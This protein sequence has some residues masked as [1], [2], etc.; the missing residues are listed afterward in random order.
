MTRPILLPSF[1]AGELSPA[2][3]GRVDLAKYQVGLATC[4]NWFV[5]PFGGVSTRAGTA[6]VGE[7]CDEGVRSRLIPFSF[8]TQ[9]TYV[10][11]FSDRKMRVVKEGGYVL[12]AGVAVAGITRASPGIV[13]TAAPHGLS[14]GDAIWL[15][16]IEGM[17]ELNRRRFTVTVMGGS[18]FALGSDT[19][20]YGNWTEGGT[21]ARVY[22][23]TT[24]YPESDLALLKYVQS[25][26]T[27]TL[28]HPSHAPRNLTRT[29][30][31]AWSL[32][33][34][35]Y[36]PTQQPPTGL[37]SSAAG[38][39]FDYVV[40]AV[41][42]ETGEE[43]VASSSV[44]ATT[45]TSKITWTNAA[46]ANS[47]NVYKGKN[48][49]YGFIG[50]AGDG[51][52]GF[53]DTTVAPDTS[54][55]PPEDKNPFDAADKYPGCST[56]HEGRQWYA[57]TNQKPQTLY[58]SASAAFNNMNT[59]S[60]S[61]DSDAI[62]RTIAS[63]E[64][65][66]I[67]HLLS[68][69]VLLVWT[70]GAVWKAWAG[71]QADVM[72]PANCA[73]KPQSYEGVSEIPPIATESAALYVTASAKKVRD[74]AYDFGSDSWAGRNVSILAGHLFE[75]H[76]LEEWAYARD[77][78]GIVWC[79]RSDGV[80][81]AF[82]Y[83]KEHDVYAWS[84]HVTDGRVES[85]AA[86]QEADETVLYLSV[87]RTVGGETKRF[88]E[89]MASRGFKD[90]QAAWCVDSGIR[91]DG[92][93]GEAGRTLAIA[94][95]GYGAGEGV[96]LTATG[97][98]PFGAASVGASY[99]LRNGQNQVTVTVVSYIDANHA[100]ATLDIAPHASL[101]DRPTEDWALA[102]RALGGLWHLEGRELAVLADGS[103]QPNATVNNGTILL[104]RASG[105]ILAGLPYVCDLET[106]GLEA[107]PP[108]L[109][110]RQKVVNEVVLRV[111]DTRGL[112]AGPTADRLVDVKERSSEQQGFPTMLTTGDEHVL[113]DPAW[114]AAGRVFV[115][116]AHPLPA[117]VL[118]IIPRLETGA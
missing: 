115:R 74:V 66:E 35:T 99:I 5:H 86:V 63:R 44:S 107:G 106:L 89:R 105:A 19:S 69:N 10:L 41:A 23:I 72:T 29:G 78:H 68:L 94:G 62:T 65:N 91:H 103:V 3:Q 51:A 84:R 82:T 76:G 80:L 75:T 90:V 98:A 61:K 24:P 58:S 38:S 83:L 33:T 114:N 101:Q 16:G 21:A 56:Y 31:A 54:D 20:G 102:S 17:R 49:V 39:G 53:T 79:V 100:G 104:P 48:A 92:W 96:T 108:T 50:R 30:H 9:Q 28:T 18:T 117:T 13:T 47:Y 8:N 64:V 1:A 112:S 85:V 37:V 7:T 36:A 71:A 60:P 59:S 70:S 4:L 77:P 11:E 95:T 40:T 87:K 32:A 42:E 111:K 93:N 45:Q 2:L 118:A 88:V 12:E 113:I 46:G 6:F 15:D 81:L 26:D 97:H 55:T 14:S 110:G 57:R 52:T 73:V 109:Q 34:I 22:T 27:M 116:Q 25:A 67:R 43:S